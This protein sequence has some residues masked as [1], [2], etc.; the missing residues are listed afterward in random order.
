MSQFWMKK[1]HRN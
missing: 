1:R